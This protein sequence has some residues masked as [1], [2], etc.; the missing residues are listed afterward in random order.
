MVILFCI[1]PLLHSSILFPFPLSFVTSTLFAYIQQLHFINMFTSFYI[2]IYSLSN[3]W[4][5]ISRCKEN[6]ISVRLILLM[7]RKEGKK[8]FNGHPTHMMN[9]KLGRY[10]TYI[11]TILHFL[12][13]PL[14]STITLS[15]SQSLIFFYL[16]IYRRVG[17]YMLVEEAW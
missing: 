2:S 10:I 9:E 14:S 8:V 15:I 12:L 1:S 16:L 3:D 6:H 4:F 5:I 17:H 13:S 11:L 7:R